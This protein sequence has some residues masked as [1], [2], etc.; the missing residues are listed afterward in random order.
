M[1]PDERPLAWSS[2]GTP[3]KPPAKPAPPPATGRVRV[4]L[5]RQGR[6]GKA[7][8]VVE[9]LPGH[10]ERIEQLA[11]ALKA[12]CGAGGTVKGRPGGGYAVE[13]QGD[14]RDRI[15]AELAKHGIHAVRAGG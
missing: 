15:V 8:S 10:P 14:Q 2:D 13:I 12:A 5:E 3:A 7:V 6:G 9:N 4:R 1:T 11:R